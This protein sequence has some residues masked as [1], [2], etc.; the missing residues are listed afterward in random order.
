MPNHVNQWDPFLISYLVPHPVRWVAAD[1]AFR[2]STKW[3]LIAIGAIA[4]VK[5]QSDIMTIQAVKNAMDVGSIAGI[6]PEGQQNW[7]GRTRPLIPATAKLIRFL[8]VPVIVAIITGGYLSKPRWSWIARRAR[9][10]IHFHQAISAEELKT[11]KLSE[12]ENR[13][14]ESLKYDE[15]AWQ[16][17]ALVPLK[18]E[19][20]AEH[21]ELAHWAC[22]SC[23]DMDSMRSDG[24]RLFCSACGY[25]VFINKYGFFEYPD[26]G[27][28]FNHPGDWNSRQK[29][30][31]EEDLHN[32]LESGPDTVLLRESELTLMRGLRAMPMLPEFTG[33]ARLYGNR[34]EV[35]NGGDNPL[36]YPFKGVSDVN[37]FKQQNFEFRY[38]KAM[39]RLSFHHLYISGYKWETAYKILNDKLLQ[40]D[41]DS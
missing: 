10:E 13:L 41:M 8:K 2:D 38:D 23:R 22:P 26:A 34:I 12:I 30:L 29:E 28:S 6:F 37:V 3:A 40:E 11:M 24:N 16:K 31:L 9:V 36:V 21:L 32:R 35:G 19:Q 1:A 14:N 33:E 17:E 20:R 27:P 39:Y 5:E 25:E 18:S 7:D 4:K 15:Y